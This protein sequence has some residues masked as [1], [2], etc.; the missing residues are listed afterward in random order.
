MRRSVAG[1]C[2]PCNTTPISESLLPLCAHAE[3]S[4]LLEGQSPQRRA[5]LLPGLYLLLDRLPCVTGSP[6]I[7]FRRRCW[8][9]C[10]RKCRHAEGLTLMLLSSGSRVGCR[11]G[12]LRSPS[13]LRCRHALPLGLGLCMVQ[14]LSVAQPTWRQSNTQAGTQVLS[15]LIIGQGMTDICSLIHLGS[16]HTT[17]PYLIGLDGGGCTLNYSA[18]INI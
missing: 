6:S 14:D 17:L 8:K 3:R 1:S 7:P 11:P 9:L 10:S 5:S 16:H 18:Y 12:R 2:N 13:V 4:V 15:G